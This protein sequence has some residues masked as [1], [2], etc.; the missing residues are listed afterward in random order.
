MATQTVLTRYRVPDYSNV[1]PLPNPPQ[2]PDML[3][4]FPGINAFASALDLWF[5]DRD[6][7]FVGALG[8]L[9]ADT[10]DRSGPYPDGVFA[11]GL[12]GAERIF[13]RNGY[14]I[15]EGIQRGLG[16]GILVGRKRSSLQRPGERGVPSDAQ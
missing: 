3:N 6:D 2:Q 7:V 4:Q 1:K 5:K 10:D 15:S 13:L 9:W 14:V 8:Y 12:D 11:E 16:S